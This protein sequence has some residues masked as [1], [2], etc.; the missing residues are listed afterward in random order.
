MD[1][2]V[3]VIGDNPDVQVVSTGF[4]AGTV[5]EQSVVLF[6]GVHELGGSQNELAGSPNAATEFLF[7]CA[8]CQHS[9][10]VVA[11]GGRS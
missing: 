9:G 10:G 5:G 4:G 2:P 3:V 1:G 8:N 7:S 6:V 11:P